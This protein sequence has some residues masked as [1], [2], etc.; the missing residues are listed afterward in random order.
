MCSFLRLILISISALLLSATISAQALERLSSLELA[1]VKKAHEFAFFSS[2]S[3]L[4]RVYRSNPV[5]EA[6]RVLAP[7]RLGDTL[8]GNPINWEAMD[9]CLSVWEPIKK[10]PITCDYVYSNGLTIG[11]FMIAVCK[12]IYRQGGFSYCC[13]SLPKG[14]F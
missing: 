14:S 2:Q 12:K 13:F 4:E 9:L 5:T 10:L 8:K 7:P 3:F 11:E 6:A 1:L